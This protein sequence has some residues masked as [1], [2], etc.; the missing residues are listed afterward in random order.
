LPPAGEFERAGARQLKKGLL[1]LAL[2]LLVDFAKLVG[3]LLH[4]FFREH[5]GVTSRKCRPNS[6]FF[7]DVFNAVQF[8]AK[9]FGDYADGSRSINCGFHFC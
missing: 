9:L 7:Y 2:S 4:G 3:N 5:T 6:A 8:F 1:I